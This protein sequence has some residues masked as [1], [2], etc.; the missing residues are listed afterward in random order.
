MYRGLAKLDQ[1]CPKKLRLERAHIPCST[2]SVARYFRTSLAKLQAHPSCFF[3]IFERVNTFCIPQMASSIPQGFVYPPLPNANAIRVLTLHPGDFDRELACTLNTFSFIEK[4]RFV[5]LSYTWVDP[6]PVA[7][8]LPVGCPTPMA[9]VATW[10]HPGSTVV[11][12]SG[13]VKLNGDSYFPVQHNLC[14]ALRHIRSS[15]HALPLW[16]DA[17]CIN[18][19]D[20]EERSSQVAQ[21]ALIFQAA[22]RVVAW[23]GVRFE[24]VLDY[25]A[26]GDGY[27]IHDRTAMERMRDAWLNGE[28]KML[29][30][31]LDLKDCHGGG[32]VHGRSSVQKARIRYSPDPSLA[33]YKL[34]FANPYWTRMWIVQE[35]CLG[36]NPTFMYGP[37]LWTLE[38][39]T[40]WPVDVSTSLPAVIG[41]EDGARNTAE[42]A[43]IRALVDTRSDLFGDKGRLEE[44]IEAFSQRHCT[45]VRDR[46]YS[47]LGLAWDVFPD[48]STSG[49]TMQVGERKASGVIRIDYQDKFFSLWSEVVLHMYYSGES[50]E[51]N[52]ANRTRV[53][54]FAGLVQA[55]LDG[56][57]EKEREMECECLELRR[58]GDAPCIA[59]VGYVASRILMLGQSYSSFLASRRLIPE[60]RAGWKSFYSPGDFRELRKIDAASSAT[61]ADLCSSE[62]NR[63]RPIDSPSTVGRREMEEEYQ[64]VP[65]AASQDQTLD[66]A[67]DPSPLR[68]LGTNYYMG[69]TPPTTKVGDIVVRFWGCDAAL[70]MRQDASGYR[71]VGR[72]HVANTHNNRDSSSADSIS[73]EMDLPTLQKISA[74]ISIFS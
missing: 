4:P 40:S 52:D 56:E 58:A 65:G 33:D 10:V 43:L 70:I 39:L 38:Q 11:G 1:I 42:D 73:V 72:A 18:Q 59:A 35:L 21:M 22:S 45:D 20:V 54:R 36:R 74:S 49:Q 46:I 67:Q 71:L 60:W 12:A 57:V 50:L 14:L 23:L 64:V 55:A 16:V 69:L 47:L 2:A 48:Y 13:F 44:L 34:L 9:A 8:S 63:I 61:Q 37:K 3:S 68:F 17:L 66:T 51:A 15:T 41:D 28:G 31:A 25:E 62:V 32:H 30:A 53:V 7:A 5:A 24:G 26:M 19:Q 29:A 27:A 6:D